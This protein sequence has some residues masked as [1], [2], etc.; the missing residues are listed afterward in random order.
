M[1]R[2]STSRTFWLT[3]LA[4][5][6]IVN[7]VMARLTQVRL[8]ELGADLARSAW[9]GM[10]AFCLILAALCLWLMFRIARGDS[11]FK[12]LDDIQFDGAGWRVSGILIFALIA[13]LIPYIKF[14]FQIGQE[15]RDPV[16][17]P[18]LLLL[19]YYWMCWWLILLAMTA[20]KA[21][22]GVTWLGGFAAA[23]LVL[24]VTFEIM[25]RFNVVVDYPFSLGWSEG[26]RFYYASLLFSERLYG[27]FTALSPYHATRYILQSL[28]F[29]V[30]GW[31]LFEHR[32]WQFLLWMVLTAG[33]TI[34]VAV[35]AIS[36]QERWLRWLL[37]GFLFLFF[38]RVG[39]YYHLQVMVI[40]TL[41]FYSGTHPRRTLTGVVL[42]SLWAGISRVNWYVMPA[43]MSTAIY[44]LETPMPAGKLSF[45]QLVSYFSKPFTWGV[46][47]IIA[48]LT[49]QAAYI[50]LSG[51][52]ENA[53]A[54][55]SS[56][57][58]DLLWYRLLPNDSFPMGIV[59]GI[60]FVSGPLLLGLFITARGQWLALHPIRWAGL[61]GSLLV[62]FAGSMVVSVKIGGGGD[63]HNTDTYA[64]LL[65]II[66]AYFLGGQVK[67][68]SGQV[69]DWGTLHPALAA[70]AVVIPILFLIPALAPYPVYREDISR[71]AQ[72]Q[73]TGAVKEAQSQGPVLFISE[74]QM[75]A[76]GEMDVPLIPEYEVVVLMEMA[77]SG[78]QPYLGRFY[79]DLQ[80]HRFAAI[81][82]GRQ[83]LGIK[84]EGVFFEENNAWNSL[85]SPYV[86]CYYEPTQTIDIGLRDI[87]IFTP[88]ASTE[89]S[90]P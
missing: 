45:R 43:L 11:F 30:P 77:M 12:R 24:G 52:A 65:G 44:L 19:F 18:V 20:W 86:L 59:L 60:L 53:R 39:V 2:T 21:A 49:A 82:S 36:A 87:Q 57:T 84:E 40:V 38:L 41:L 89:C 8:L 47:G 34:T 83:N 28:A 37:A 22:F 25:T 75:L 79:S 14:K 72:E 62:M 69:E 73:L 55:T 35:R 3:L 13:F 56:F 15:V 46:I 32:L 29:L 6:V 76:F 10:L 74:R 67:P 48:A 26:S 78:N 63:L 64:V 33:A 17:D 51:N 70:V 81:V 42:A 5:T 7:L 80:N 54:F 50:S 58:S 85:V 31:G 27:E 88:R 4:F 16:Y 9:S 90:L 68:D 1:N 23:L 66:V 71:S 61:F